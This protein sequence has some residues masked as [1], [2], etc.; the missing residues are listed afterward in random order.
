MTLLDPEPL[1]LCY[2]PASVV[3]LHEGIIRAWRIPFSN[4]H[5]VCVHPQVPTGLYT[6]PPFP[7]KQNLTA[8]P[9]LLQTSTHTLGTA[10][11]RPSFVSV[12]GR[13]LPYSWVRRGVGVRGGVH[14]RRNPIPPLPSSLIAFAGD[15]WQKF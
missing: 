10:H 7:L 6:L 15:F 3:V 13:I 9:A 11:P 2:I 1:A 12:G 5:H 14:K 4:S 8:A